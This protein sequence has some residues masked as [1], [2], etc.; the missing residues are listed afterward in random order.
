M[1]AAASPVRVQMLALARHI[2]GG[3]DAWKKAGARS[4][5]SSGPD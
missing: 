3:I 2:Q 1:Q 5:L 4:G